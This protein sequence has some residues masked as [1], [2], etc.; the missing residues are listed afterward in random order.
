MYKKTARKLGWALFTLALV[1]NAV[2]IAAALFIEEAAPRFMYSPWYSMALIALGMYACGFPLFMLM[3]RN[4]PDDDERRGEAE[5]SVKEVAKLYIM[6]MGWAYIFSVVGM[7]LSELIAALTGGMASNPVEDISNM[8]G[9]LPMAIGAG[10]I[11]PIVEEIIFRKVLLGRAL[12]YGQKAAVWFTAITFGLL[13]MNFYQ[14]FYA[15]ALG[16]IFGHIAVKTGGIKYTVILHIMIN[17]TSAVLVPAITVF[18]TEGVFAGLYVIAMIIWG[19]TLWVKNR[20]AITA[21]KVMPRENALSRNRGL[22]MSAFENDTFDPDYDLS[23]GRDDMRMTSNEV[24]GRELYLNSGFI[25]Y[26]LLCAA[27]MIYVLL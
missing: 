27:G 11:S 15:T 12:P 13:H 25:A 18:D 22:Y 5:L 3:T 23:R 20:K 4:L 24:K 7:V 10:I 19:M 2:E 6:C 9:V 8:S 14:F 17:M 26:A 21:I 16:Y 1:T